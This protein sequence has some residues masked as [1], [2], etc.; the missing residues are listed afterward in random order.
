MLKG[1]RKD[2]FQIERIFADFGLDGAYCSKLF[3]CQRRFRTDWDGEL[4]K[5]VTDGEAIFVG[6]FQGIRSLPPKEQDIGMGTVGWMWVSRFLKGERI[7]MRSKLNSGLPLTFLLN[8]KLRKPFALP[9]RGC[10]TVGTF[11]MK[12]A[13]PYGW[14]WSAR[15]SELTETPKLRECL[16]LPMHF[17]P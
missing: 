2:D 14:I 5:W 9:R 8:L 4:E 16:A 15:S 7:V 10:L 12:F 17:N 3:G 13:G 1:V 6:R 11:C